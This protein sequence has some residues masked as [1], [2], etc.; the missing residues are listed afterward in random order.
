MPTS[1]P[2]PEF[3]ELVGKYLSMGKR[4]KTI[5]LGQLVPVTH[6]M[7]VTRRLYVVG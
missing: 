7:Y 4:V 3:W 6:T 2:G 5:H 1:E